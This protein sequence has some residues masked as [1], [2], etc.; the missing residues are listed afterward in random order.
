MSTGFPRLT[1]SAK[2][3]ELGVNIISRQVTDGF[4]WLFRRNH[5][6]HDF[7]IDGQIELVTQDGS[8]TGQMLAVQIKCGKSFFTEQNKWGYVYRGNN[9]HFNYLANYP[10]PVI[11][12]ICNPESGESYWVHF[13][14]EHVQASKSNWKITIPFGNKLAS[15]KNSLERLVPKVSDSLAELDTYWKTNKVLIDAPLILFTFDEN[16]V[17][18]LN[19]KRPRDFFDRIRTT[20]ELAYACKGKIEFSFSGY[21]DDPRELFEIE[22]VRE[23]VSRLDSILPEFLFFVRTKT[24]TH[25]IETFALCQTDVEFEWIAKESGTYKVNFS[26]KEVVDFY[27]RHFCGLNVMAEWLDLSEDETFKIAMEALDCMGLGP[28]T[29]GLKIFRDKDI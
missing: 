21:D 22:E 26:T 28:T 16:D 19:I 29:D 10:L 25:T 4:G 17:T 1:D 27:E 12:C 5:Q 18:E 7:G 23:F 11:I 14:K 13:L 20:K 3:G 6:E 9:K 8:V 2:L 24:P 15:S